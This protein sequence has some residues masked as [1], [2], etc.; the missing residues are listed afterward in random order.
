MF[1]AEGAAEGQGRPLR[2]VGLREEQAPAAVLGK[3]RA[4]GVT[5][6]G[7]L[8]GLTALEVVELTGLRPDRAAAVRREV[9]AAV[10]AP[11]RTALQLLRQAR[12]PLPSRLRTGVERLDAA[13]GGGLPA[14]MVVEL[15]GPPGS[16]KSQFCLGAAARTAVP[17]RTDAGLSGQVLYI[18]TEAKFG[19]SPTG[20]GGVPGEPRPGPGFPPDRSF[21]GGGG[22]P[23][24]P[25][26]SVPRGGARSWD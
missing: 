2:R 9:A 21:G 20:R 1:S 4:R 24:A 23:A 5:T 10:Q 15:V 8:L 6:V 7:G 22:S 12:G 26:G 3:L 14:G 19:E 13:L 16:G 25:R 18:D 17:G 11:P